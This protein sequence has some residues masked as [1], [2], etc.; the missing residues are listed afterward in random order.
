MAFGKA[1]MDDLVVAAFAEIEQETPDDATIGVVMMTVEVKLRDPEQTAIYTFSTDRRVW[2]QRAM[3][4]EAIDT[5]G[6]GV[7]NV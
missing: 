3:L 4:A 1:K 7:E 2:V 6:L 5:V